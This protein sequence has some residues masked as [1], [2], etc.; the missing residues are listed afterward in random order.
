MKEQ[1]QEV[2]P[3]EILP[4]GHHSGNAAA[5]LKEMLDDVAREIASLDIL[6]RMLLT[7]VIRQQSG[8]SVED[9]L[10]AAESLATLVQALDRPDLVGD[11]DRRRQIITMLAEWKGKLERLVSCFQMAAQLT[12]KYV[13]DPGE[14]AGSLDLLAQRQQVVRKLIR[15]IEQIEQS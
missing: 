5:E 10:R 14:L 12:D 11:V 15:E 1:K 2:I 6:R 3:E 7:G 13:Q 9:W 4:A 8:M